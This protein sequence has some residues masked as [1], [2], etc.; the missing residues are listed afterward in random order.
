M[1]K[2]LF[3]FDLDGT[4]ADTANLARGAREPYDVLRLVPPGG[5]TSS[6]SFGEDVCELPAKLMQ[7][8]AFVVIITRSPRAY[9]STLTG[10]LDIDYDLGFANIQKPYPGNHKKALIETIQYL[11]LTHDIL[12]NNYGIDT[13]DDY[14]H[15]SASDLIYIGDT[16]IDREAAEEIGI[17]YRHA[18]WSSD[19]YQNLL[20]LAGG[21]R[22]L[23]PARW[24]E[25]IQ[26]ETLSGI[27]H[28][29]VE[30][31]PITFHMLM[32]DYGIHALNAVTDPE[33]Y[34]I[35]LRDWASRLK[36]TSKWGIRFNANYPNWRN[37]KSEP[38]I[39]DRMFAALSETFPPQK[40]SVDG[41]EGDVYAFSSFGLS[42]LFG[43]SLHGF[44]KDWSGQ[45]GQRSGRNVHLGFLNFL[46]VAMASSI[47]TYAQR[48]TGIKPSPPPLP[49]DEFSPT[50]IAALL[51]E[52]NLTFE[53]IDVHTG[54]FE[55]L[56]TLGV[57]EPHMFSGFVQE[58]HFDLGHK[59]CPFCGDL[60][61]SKLK[62]FKT[63]WSLYETY[64]T[65][66]PDD[67]LIFY[68][69]NIGDRGLWTSDW[70]SF[71][72]NTGSRTI[73]S[74][75][76]DENG[77]ETTFALYL[78][79]CPNCKSLFDC[80]NEGIPTLDEINYFFPD[81]N[82]RNTFSD[83]LLSDPDINDYRDSNALEFF[84]KDIE[85]FAYDYTPLHSHLD[86]HKARTAQSLA[87]TEK[88]FVV[89]VPATPC[90]R[91]QP[92]QV[93]ERLAHK[94]AEFGKWEFLN[95]LEKGPDANEVRVR[96]SQRVPDSGI[97][98][99]ID[100]QLTHGGSMRR[101]QNALVEAGVPSENIERF[102]WSISQQHHERDNQ[103]EVEEL[104]RLAAIDK[105]IRSS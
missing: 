80:T 52:L 51:Q 68:E 9:A 40:F 26:R 59:F 37:I 27:A 31:W 64:E 77:G 11:G 35:Y 23:N 4:L 71:A 88:I 1:T 30:E 93:S 90:T 74:I 48:E 103:E 29:L 14:Q 70:H 38:N 67:R 2:R 44:L 12:R 21:A 7:R 66:E 60:G 8:G 46:A 97:F 95:C 98:I 45:T 58:Y 101:A 73:R 69:S 6:I 91:D 53:D 79:L 99:L 25:G 41:I 61:S 43:T 89:P 10:L 3:I 50:T 75:Y 19:L 36:E 20:D 76:P 81:P 34:Q 105:S 39:K 87:L 5:D 82:L 65:E 15:F 49:S 42:P 86:G 57:S 24:E 72:S 55:E 63:Y 96:E 94:I 22:S 33:D 47:K 100:D 83:P 84:V 18:D 102:V 85:P 28:D 16:P 78:F 13:F 56:Q 62:S 17:T 32:R 54:F 104:R 92:G